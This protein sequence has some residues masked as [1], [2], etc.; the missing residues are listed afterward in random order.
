MRKV[1]AL[2]ICT[3]FFAG[4]GTS[5]VVISNGT[6]VGGQVGDY[7]QYELIDFPTLIGE[8]LDEE[9]YLRYSNYKTS[10]ILMELTSKGETMFEGESV[11]FTAGKMTWDE[12]VTLY[13][14]DISDD[15]DGQEDIVTIHYFM[16]QEVKA[17]GDIFSA[18]NYTV[19]EESSTFIM[20]LNMTINTYED[21]ANIWSTSIERMST[22]ILNS[23]GGM[24][25]ELKLG[26]TWTEVVT[27]RDTGTSKER[28]CDK[29]STDDC[30]WEY[31]EIDE[32]ETTTTTY[33]ALRELS[34]DTPAGTF[35][36]L[37][38]VEIE[39]GEDSGNYTLTYVNDQNLPIA[40]IYYEDNSIFMQA[41]LK[42][43]K[44]S[45]LGTLNLEALDDDENP[46][47]SSPILLSLAAIALVASR[48]RKD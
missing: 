19:I 39:E 32:E 37:E 6:E 17:M 10:G 5:E 31:E 3:L 26:S 35:D 22:E 12:E 24:P 23:T 14:D 21:Q 42:S 29:D 34:M 28:M 13:Y 25:D 1:I 30:E 45:G 36:V 44:I 20:N 9:K 8:A 43:Y 46:L 38:V 4:Q 27:E 33:Q 7:I 11:D 48:T 40:M 15:G 41:Q 47:P 18:S 16:Q 2:I